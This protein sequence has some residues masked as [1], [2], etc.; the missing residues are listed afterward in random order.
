MK[1][2]FGEPITADDTMDIQGVE[3][4]LR[5]VGI[6]PYKRMVRL[7]REAKAAEDNEMSIDAVIDFIVANV[8][9]EQREQLARHID[10][11]VPPALLTEISRGL[12]NGNSDVDPTPPE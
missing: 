4:T 11:T 5:P 9:P 12:S 3:Y 8:V 10:E 1:L 7:Q 2:K 6:G